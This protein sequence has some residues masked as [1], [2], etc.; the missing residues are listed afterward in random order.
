MSKNFISFAYTLKE[1][2]SEDKNS[3]VLDAYGLQYINEG[4]KTIT[5]ENL[6]NKKLRKGILIPE[7]FNN[8][9]Y[10]KNLIECIVNFLELASQNISMNKKD[11]DSKLNEQNIPMNMACM[12]K[13]LTGILQWIINCHSWNSDEFH[14]FDEREIK[15]KLSLLILGE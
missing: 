3:I 12:V 7:S 15:R 1:D 4:C 6:P 13:Q 9:N 14:N 2:K 11:S 10:T 5:K 8:G